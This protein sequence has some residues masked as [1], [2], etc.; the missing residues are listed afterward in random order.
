MY[1]PLRPSESDRHR[2][3]GVLKKGYV[4]GRL[5]TE[6]FEERVAVAHTTPSRGTL[7]ALMADVSGRWLA[8]HTLL[9][10]S[11]RPEARTTEP[12]ASLM[13]SRCGRRM[14]LVGR[15]RTCDLVF[16]SSAVS[17]RHARFELVGE[18]WHVTD[19]DSMNGTYVD[20][21]RVDRAPVATGSRVVLGDSVLDIS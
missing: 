19:M 3:I 4:A 11:E 13:L 17:R 1:L 15:A 5:S 6:T 10:P 2:A 9:R 7:R 16:G 20:G 8:A 12:W 21:V 18:Q 14:V